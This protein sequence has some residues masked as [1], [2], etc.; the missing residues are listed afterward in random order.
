MPV[1]PPA[2]S[3]DP[4]ALAAQAD[5]D[6]LF[7]FVVAPALRL[8]AEPPT[9]DL[10]AFVLAPGPSPAWP[11]EGWDGP[12]ALVPNYPADGWMLDSVRQALLGE[13]HRGFAVMLGAAF[14]RQVR[15]WLIHLRPA[16]AAEIEEARRLPLWII[17][18]DVTEID[19]ELSP[20]ARPLEE[21]WEI[22]SAMRHGSGRA[23]RRLTKLAPRL[24]PKAGPALNNRLPDPEI[25]DEDLWLYHQAVML[26]WGRVG[27]TPPVGIT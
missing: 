11:A 16:R 22:V 5:M 23:M 26:F 4:V 19:I 27:A 9:V 1:K 25:T 2:A 13:C 7:K 3:S 18:R 17:V 15:S 12:G 24:W 21:L 8:V 14:E 10:S 20:I 6:R